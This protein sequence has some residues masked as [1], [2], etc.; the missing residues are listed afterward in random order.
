MLWNVLALCSSCISCFHGLFPAQSWQLYV[1]LI[2]HLPAIILPAYGPLISVADSATC[3]PTTTVPLPLASEN[4]C[5]CVR[6]DLKP[7]ITWLTSVLFVSVSGLRLPT[8]DWEIPGKLK[9][10]PGESGVSR[11][12]GPYSAGYNVRES[13]LQNRHF[14]PGNWS[15]WSCDQLW[16][17]SL[18]SHDQA[19]LGLLRIFLFCYVF[20]SGPSQLWQR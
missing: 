14:Q 12:M 15:L 18:W 1:D 6:L 16:L 9:V 10:K 8:V 4:Y 3:L 20:R 7:M 11:G 5:C 13:H 19:L 17:W 2:F